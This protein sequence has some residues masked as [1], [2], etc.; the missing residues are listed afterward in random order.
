MQGPNRQHLFLNQ[1][2]AIFATTQAAL[3][4]QLTSGKKWS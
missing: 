2:N 4:M 1:S 3:K